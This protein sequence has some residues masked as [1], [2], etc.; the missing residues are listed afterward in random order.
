[1]NNPVMWIGAMTFRANRLT[2]YEQLDAKLDPTGRV[3]VQSIPE[4]FGDW[5]LREKKRGDTLGHVYDHVRKKTERGVSTAE[6]LRPFLDN[7]EYLVLAGGETQGDLRGAVNELL[8]SSSARQEM[9]DATIAAMWAPVLGLLTL[10]VMS[11][12]LGIYLWPEYERAIAIHYW[13]GW[14]R[15]GVEVQ[16]WFGKNWA[17]SLVLVVL[18]V[19]YAASLNKW[20]GRTRDW[21][22][23][24]PPWSIY[25]GRLG[26]NILTTL[27]S[28]VGS[29]K[30]VREALVMIRDRAAPYLRSHIDRIIRRYD[31]PGVEGV[32]ALRT[33]LFSQRMMDRIEDAATGRS[34]DETL[35]DVGER[36]L[37]LIVRTLKAQAATA[38]LLLLIVVGV[39]LTYI[40][41]VIVFGTQ[42][43][44][45]AALR[46]LSGGASL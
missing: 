40:S 28:L 6:A 35:K 10:V 22:D 17:A 46:G 34:F 26:A 43:A 30:S 12:G 9:A 7:D 29:G 18:M 42:E 37:K 24:L 31:S 5:A 23:K 27:A 4:I 45:E 41:C 25:K 8:R 21:F 19:V 1:M 20:T 32:G 44:T 38:S 14:A 33:G 36:S 11:I 15:P 2:I 39:L 16:L 13:P 3:A